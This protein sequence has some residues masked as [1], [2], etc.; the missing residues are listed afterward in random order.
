MPLP[1]ENEVYPVAGPVKRDNRKLDRSAALSAESLPEL[2]E[3]VRDR[4]ARVNSE[5]PVR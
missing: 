5:R 1:G 3:Q 4:I 2:R